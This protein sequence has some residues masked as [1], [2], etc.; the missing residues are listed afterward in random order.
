MFQWLSVVLGLGVAA[1]ADF[2]TGV[3]LE[4]DEVS[5][6]DFERER[7]RG[8]FLRGV[9]SSSSISFVTVS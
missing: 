2:V 7:D 8:L 6:F 3:V 9:F 1:L 4:A 5:D